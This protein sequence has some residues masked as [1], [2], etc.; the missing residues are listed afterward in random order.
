M[1]KM[2]IPM[3]ALLLSLSVSLT[4][5]AAE[6][7]T[8]QIKIPESVLNISQENTYPNPSQDLPTLQPSELTKQL[9]K[10]TNVEIANPE[11]VRL[12]NES[13]I[14]NTKLS[15]GYG[16][17]VYLG[18]WPLNYESQET[19]INW[20]YKQASVNQLD[21]RGGNK[22]AVIRYV[23]EEESKVTGDL[24]VRVSSSDDVK[25]MMI[26]KAAQK[27]KLPLSFETIVGKG[28]KKD[29]KYNV[30]PKKIGQLYGYV[31]AVSEKGKVTYGE[32]YLVLKGTR[33][34]LKVKNITQHG[35]GAWIPVQDHL[36]FKFNAQ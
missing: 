6:K 5:T 23:Q 11:L 24:T 1:K 25:K 26:I 29:Q 31:P 12:L 13:S 2:L 32:V 16:A 15:L 30:A 22:P 17:E 3:L 10:S 19:S 18:K 35:I 4:E 20:E 28:T 34:Y 14:R 33:S 7:P 9:L 8:K 27:S 21:N 36:S